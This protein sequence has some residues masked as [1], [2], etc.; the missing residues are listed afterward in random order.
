ML[1][2]QV[3]ITKLENMIVLFDYSRRLYKMRNFYNCPYFLQMLTCVS[4]EL[5]WNDY[6]KLSLQLCFLS[7]GFIGFRQYKLH[8][9]VTV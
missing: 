6:L 2:K 3:C 1:I 4:L 9:L 5:D 7:K 8:N